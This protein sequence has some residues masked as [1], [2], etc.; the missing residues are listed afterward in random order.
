METE[1]NSILVINGCRID[2]AYRASGSYGTYII[3]H[4][5]KA[6]NSAILFEPTKD[7]HKLC[8]VEQHEAAYE[9]WL[10]SLGF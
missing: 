4:G 8:T 2:T 3:E 1:T 5:K 10:K 9:D 6:V 7:I